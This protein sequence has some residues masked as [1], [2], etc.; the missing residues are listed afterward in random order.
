MS[1]S[2][3][4]LLTK[5]SSQLDALVVTT[6]PLL[7]NEHSF[8]KSIHRYLHPD[9]HSWKIHDTYTGGV[10][11]A[12]YS[13][14]AG[15]LFVEYKYVKELP[16]K[17]TTSIKTSLSALQLQWL[18]RVNQPANAALIIGVADTCIIIL[19]DFSSIIC[20]D[21]YIEQSLSR[22]E[23][24]QFIYSVTHKPQEGTKNDRITAAR[25]TE[26]SKDLGF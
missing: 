18:N 3:F 26:S 24:A 11:D 22:K 2:Q 25:S 10:P 14:P 1:A 15:L 16:K 8:I 12:M 20:K 21:S 19:D 5:I 9:V 6:H 4:V 7:M 17:A 13:G 23:A